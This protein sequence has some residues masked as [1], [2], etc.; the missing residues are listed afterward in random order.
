MKLTAIGIERGET[1][2]K[3]LERLGRDLELL[4][5]NALNFG[6]NVKVP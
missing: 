1:R 2:K 5:A 6:D 3:E 4:A